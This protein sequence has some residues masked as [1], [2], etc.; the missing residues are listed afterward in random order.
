MTSKNVKT[1]EIEY[2]VDFSK[3][4]ITAVRCDLKVSKV[5]VGCQDKKSTKQIEIM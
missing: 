1:G 3:M 2:Q 5:R 4:A